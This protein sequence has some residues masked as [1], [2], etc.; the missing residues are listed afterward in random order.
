M[1]NFTTERIKI[2]FI[3]NKLDNIYLVIMKWYFSPTKK[4]K[5]KNTHQLQLTRIPGLAT[6]LLL[7]K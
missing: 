5:N 3:S 7:N 1:F 2:L 4:W 6:E